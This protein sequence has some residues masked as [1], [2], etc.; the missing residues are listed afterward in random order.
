MAVLTDSTVVV[1]VVA[2][3]LVSA[4]GMLLLLSDYYSQCYRH[5]VSG[6][7]LYPELLVAVPRRMV[8]KLF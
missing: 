3:I 7:M 4:W 2:V 1:V 8:I 6:I 5:V